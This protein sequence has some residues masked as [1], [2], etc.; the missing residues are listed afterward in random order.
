MQL[1]LTD[2]SITLHLA[3][4]GSEGLA[5]ARNVLPSFIM[6]DLF[7]PDM[8]GST[9]LTWLK[10]DQKLGNIPVIIITADLLANEKF[11]IFSAGAAACLIK[12]VIKNRLVDIL[13]QLF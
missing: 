3:G 11:N 10:N 1:Y 5:M 8:D 9:L 13:S 7:L 2:M 4:N 6:M 12:P